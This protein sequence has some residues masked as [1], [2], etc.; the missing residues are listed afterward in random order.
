MKARKWKFVFGGIFR[1]ARMVCDAYTLYPDGRIILHG[2]EL[3]DDDI[4]EADRIGGC[5]ESGLKGNLSRFSMDAPDQSWGPMRVKG[6][7]FGSGR[8]T[9][10][11]EF[12]KV[13]DGTRGRQDERR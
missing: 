11:V 3:A 8:R 2:A 5:L 13:A 10:E 12:R 6:V 4:L 1:R 9:A 7:T